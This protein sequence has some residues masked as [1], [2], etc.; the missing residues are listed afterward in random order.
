[1]IH[2]L[3][4]LMT[5]SIIE[6][7]ICFET[8]TKDS[9]KGIHD[10]LQLALNVLRN[11]LTANADGVRNAPKQVRK[12]ALTIEL[13]SFLCLLYFFVFYV[14]LYVDSQN[15]E[16]VQEK[17][18]FL[19]VSRSELQNSEAVQWSRMVSPVRRRP[20]HVQCQICCSDGELK[21]LAITAR[22]HGRYS[23][24]QP[25]VLI[26]IHPNTLSLPLSHTRTAGV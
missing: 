11:G 20:R 23:V 8:W 6:I 7:H 10:V 12:T 1:M 26:T 9:E 13:K 15:R 25:R 5:L 17:F 19:V 16:P 18:S 4:L 22:H 2:G 3:W 24:S 21:Q 14:C